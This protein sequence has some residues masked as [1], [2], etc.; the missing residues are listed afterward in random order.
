MAR[1]ATEPGIGLPDRSVFS[2]KSDEKFSRW[3]V[4]SLVFHA[5]LIGAIFLFPC[6]RRKK[7]PNTPCI[8]LISSAVKNRP[9]EPWHEP[10]PR[11]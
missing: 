3:L 10:R 1:E 5:A 6:C 11:R 4:F 9:D 2:F 7:P 8:R